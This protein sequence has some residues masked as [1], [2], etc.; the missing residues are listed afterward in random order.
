ML[1]QEDDTELNDDCLADDEHLIRFIKARER[2]VGRVKG[3]ESP[4]FQGTQSS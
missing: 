1:K 3:V 2:I 4:S